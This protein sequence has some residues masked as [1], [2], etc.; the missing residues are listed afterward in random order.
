MRKL[1]II[2]AL[3]FLAL[4]AHAQVLETSSGNAVLV[5]SSGAGLSSGY[6]SRNGKALFVQHDDS[7]LDCIQQLL[8]FDQRSLWHDPRK[9]G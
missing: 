4:P 3:L 5:T 2:F 6:S 1:P 9:A 8:G 7:L